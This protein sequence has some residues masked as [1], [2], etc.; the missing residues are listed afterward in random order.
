MLLPQINA[1][2]A[3][4]S[5]F[6]RTSTITNLPISQLILRHTTSSDMADGFGGGLLFAIQ[7]NANTSNLIAGIRAIR[8]GADNSGRLSFATYTTGTDSEKMTILPDGKVGIGTASPARLLSLVTSTNNDGIQIRRNSS[9]TNDYAVL[10]FRIATSEVAVNLAEIRGLRTNRDSSADTDLTFLTSSG[11]SNPTE[12]MRI[13]DDGL[14]GINET[15]PSAQLQV[16]SGAT[17]RIPLIVDTLNNHTALLQDWRKN[18]VSVARITDAGF[19]QSNQ[20]YGST[21]TFGLY[22][23]TNANSASVNVL[24]TGTVISRNIA[25]SNPAL[26]TNIANASSTANVQVWQK[27][28]SALLAV[29]NDGSLINPTA[30][31]SKLSLTS[32]GALIER[33]INDAE[34]ALKINQQQGTGK[35]ASF[36]FGGV[37][38]SY[39]DKDGNFSGASVVPTYTFLG[40]R[41]G[42]AGDGNITVTDITTFDEIVA[43]FIYDNDAAQL[44]ATRVQA[45]V[46]T[47]F[48]P[49]GGGDLVGVAVMTFSKG[50]T[51]LATAT[52]GKGDNNTTLVVDFG[53]TVADA[54]LKVYGINY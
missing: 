14:V 24:T 53:G 28:T 21:G 46:S 54:L 49:G 17:N 18:G 39:I 31:N 51:T 36:Q 3:N 4:I 40:S 30:A 32:T 42:S 9:T 19:F 6:E 45:P 12:K 34:V 16:K 2:S 25:D 41:A 7:D 10:G 44:F 43:E 48:Q 47:H 38:K 37:E 5:S 11:G 23:T 20:G 35:I 29:G 1:S 33:N 26:I 50:G 8:S 27:A 22:F 15:S 52:V 13:R